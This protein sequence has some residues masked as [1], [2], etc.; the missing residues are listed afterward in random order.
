M[1]G[2]AIRQSQALDLATFTAW[3]TAMFALSGYAGKLKGKSLSDFLTTASQHR[4]HALQN[5]QAIAWA[6]RMKA[7]G[8]DV[9]I[10]RNPVN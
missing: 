9:Q 1:E 3:H 5:A 4:P 8:F 10:T 6:H 2:A 7:K